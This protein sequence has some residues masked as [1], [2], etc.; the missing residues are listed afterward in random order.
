VVLDV[1][2]TLALPCVSVFDDGH[3]VYVA[4]PEIVA[5]SLFD[6]LETGTIELRP[7]NRQHTFTNY[8]FRRRNF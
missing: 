8:T 1:S 3:V 2:E 6:I 5:G 7:F 4:K